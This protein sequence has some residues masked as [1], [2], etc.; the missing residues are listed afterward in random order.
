MLVRCFGMGKRG[1]A[2]Q[3]AGSMR[4]RTPGSWELRAYGGVD[5]LT[6]R[7]VTGHAPCVNLVVRS[8][9]PPTLQ[10]VAWFYQ[11]F[12]DCVA[13]GARLSGPAPSGGGAQQRRGRGST[14]VFV[15]KV[16]GRWTA[17]E[18]FAE[19]RPPTDDDVPIALNGTRLDTPAKVLA[20]LEEINAERERAQQRVG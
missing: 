20:Y 8:T 18:F 9:R 16:I 19:T 14:L 10:G 5:A 11:E 7:S 15:S 2:I 13:P 6:A 3:P 4:Q 1:R 12:R 17:E